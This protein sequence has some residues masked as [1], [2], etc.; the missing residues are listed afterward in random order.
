MYKINSYSMCLVTFQYQAPTFPD[1]P[2]TTIIYCDIYNVNAV[3]ARIP[4]KWRFYI[5]I[6]SMITLES[7]HTS[8]KHRQIYRLAV[9]Q[10]GPQIFTFTQL[11]DGRV[12]WAIHSS[13]AMGI[14]YSLSKGI[15]VCSCNIS[16]LYFL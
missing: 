2:S 13:E 7:V 16:I 3:C 9:E 1:L 12:K 5:V 10:M 14:S 8:T 15:R 6:T 11:I 4:A